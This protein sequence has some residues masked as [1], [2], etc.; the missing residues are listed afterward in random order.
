MN[1]QFDRL[2]DKLV[3]YNIATEDEIR[4]VC[5]INGHTVETLES[6]LYAKVGYR[7][8]TQLELFYL[9]REIEITNNLMEGM[10][11]DELH[12]IKTV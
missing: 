8:E 6:I 10:E 7:S 5:C 12:L 11:N 3:R 1:T 2:Y 9:E 4:L